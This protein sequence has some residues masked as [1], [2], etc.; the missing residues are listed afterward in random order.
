MGHVE[1]YCSCLLLIWDL[2]SV[3]WVDVSLPFTIESGANCLNVIILLAKFVQYVNNLTRYLFKMLTMSACVFG[4][5]ANSITFAGD[6]YH[7]LSCRSRVWPQ[8]T[9]ESTDVRCSISIMRFGVTQQQSLL[10]R[11]MDIIFIYIYCIENVWRRNQR[12]IDVKILM[13]IVWLCKYEHRHWKHYGTKH[14]LILYF[15]AGPTSITDAPWVEAHRG[16][17]MLLEFTLKFKYTGWKKEAELGFS[18]C[19]MCW[20][21]S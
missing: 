8:H 5:C 1:P 9:E 10:V 3:Y 11:L 18:S 16:P 4:L 12:Y 7:C 13:M 19:A 15:N 2:L 6:A 20:N 21:I 17:G 14:V